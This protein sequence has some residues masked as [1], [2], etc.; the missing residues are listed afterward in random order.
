V[1]TESETSET[2]E[3]V[4]ETPETPAV[5]RSIPTFEEFVNVA[6]FQREQYPTPEKAAE[7]LG[8]TLSTFKQRVKRELKNFKEVFET[9]EWKNYPTGKA[10]RTPTTKETAMEAF[11]RIKAKNEAAANKEGQ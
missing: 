1:V 11:A 5:K 2:V 8:I 3:A 7:A 6:H 4:V 9:Y 10:G